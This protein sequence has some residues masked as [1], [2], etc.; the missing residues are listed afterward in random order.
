MNDKIRNLIIKSPSKDNFQPKFIDE[1]QLDC[2]IY[3]LKEIIRINNISI[4]NKDIDI[5]DPDN[6][7]NSTIFGNLD[8]NKILNYLK[9]KKFMIYSVNIKKNNEISLYDYM[10]LTF[11]D[12]KKNNSNN[13]ANINKNID[14]ELKNILKFFHCFARNVLLDINKYGSGTLFID[15]LKKLKNE[16]NPEKIYDLNNLLFSNMQNR[17]NVQKPILTQ[18]NKY[19]IS[20]LINV[21][22]SN[23]MSYYLVILKLTFE[24]IKENNYKVYKEL[25]NRYPEFHSIVNKN[26]D[27][28]KDRLFINYFF[29]DIDYDKDK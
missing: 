5:V 19:T 8:R 17:D 9:F 4:Y 16:V 2:Y 20:L 22:N 28:D 6:V 7:V 12:I 25:I 13:S 29:T 24:T 3:I 26:P 23:I 15:K 10:R 14:Q 18:R 1:S 27:T 11:S 21:I